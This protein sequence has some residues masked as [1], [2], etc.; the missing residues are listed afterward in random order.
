ML[1]Q[2]DP[3]RTVAPSFGTRAGYTTAWPDLTAKL[4]PY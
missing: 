4:K 1:L 2:I 3:S